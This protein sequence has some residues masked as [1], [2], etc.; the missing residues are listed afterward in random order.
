MPPLLCS[1]MVINDDYGKMLPPIVPDFCFFPLLTKISRA[2]VKCLF[3]SRKKSSLKFL[4]FVLHFV[5]LE[6]E[7][8]LEVLK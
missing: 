1:G 7:R 8:L 2:F 4:L 3:L 6:Y 5:Y